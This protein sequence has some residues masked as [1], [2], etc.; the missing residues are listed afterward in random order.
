MNKQLTQ[1]SIAFGGIFLLLFLNLTNLQ[2]FDASGLNNRADNKRSLY[3]QYDVDRGAIIISGSPVAYSVKTTGRFK[4]ERRYV[5]SAFTHP[6]GYLSAIYGVSGIEQSENALLS[7]DADSL[8]VDRIRQ[9]L[10][11]GAKRGGSTSLT[12]DAEAQSL[13][14]Q[15][16]GGRRGAVVAIEPKT[17][18]VLVSASSPS[19]DSNLLSTTNAK[20]MQSAWQKL[21]K[22][23]NQ[24]ILNRAYAQTWAPGSVFKLITTAAAL[25]SGKYTL[26]T[27]IPAPETYKLPGSTKEISN[28]Q[29]TACSKSGEVTLSVALEVSC[30]TAFARVGVDIGINQIVKT[31]T[32]FGFGTNFNLPDYSIASVVPNKVDAAQTALVAIGQFDV[33]SSALQMALVTAAIGN[34]G[35]VMTPQLIDEQIGPNLK[36]IKNLDP[37]VFNRAIKPETANALKEMMLNVVNQG[38]ASN[39]R[40]KGIAV[41][42]KTG[43]AETLPGSAPHAWFVALAPAEN[44]RV[45]IA[46]IVENGG[47]AKGKYA[48]EVSGN[49]IAAP[50]ARQLLV[51]LL[52]LG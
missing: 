49:A 18:R 9:L 36:V 39:A 22:D 38:T 46:V 23:P 6:V 11:G 13:A 26:T 20:T 50:I 2:V 52:S 48:G 14:Y 44:P 43:T 8:T 34:E 37:K 42:G 28:W 17:G 12:L 47:Y 33:Q 1:V 16:L 30:N 21:L 19:F 15:L 24:P 29:K 40:I 45:A 10:D 4:Y 27:K 5:S 31:A 51:D 7:G 41:A 35:V 3:Q 32:A 25:E